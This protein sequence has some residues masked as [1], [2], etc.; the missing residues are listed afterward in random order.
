M[1]KPLLLILTLI[2]FGLYGFLGL[3]LYPYFFITGFKEAQV[4]RF[5]YILAR[6][7]FWVV[8]RAAKSFTLEGA[9]N[10]PAGAAVIAANHSSILDILCMAEFG[11]EDIIFIMRG[12]P[13]KV[14]VM[15][16]YARAAGNI[17]LES[18]L[19]SGDALKAAAARAFKKG[20][21]IIVFPEG[22]RGPEGFLRRFH[23]GAFMLA[24]DFKVPLVP[25]ALK[26]LGGMIPKRG[27]WVNATDIKISAL[28]PVENF[29]APAGSAPALKMAQY[30]KTLIAK[31]LEEK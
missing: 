28:P 18:S 2:G 29:T 20:L 26:G 3:A 22:T 8:K 1:K 19:D 7:V 11:R 14:P 9:R 23:S 21:K 27:F 30:V 13:S 15:G 25:V 17:C 31:K 12:W 10:I 5:F 4:R 6:S 24:L 16:A